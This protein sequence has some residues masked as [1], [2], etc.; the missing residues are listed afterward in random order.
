MAAAGGEGP[1]TPGRVAVLGGSG[2]VGTALLRVLCDRDAHVVSVDLRPAAVEDVES[3]LADIR[4]D[5]WE[6][7]LAGCELL[8]NLVGT[9]D[10][11]RSMELPFDD[12]ECNCT[13]ALAALRAAR[14]AGIRDVCYASTRQV[15]GR[16]RTLPVDED[17]PLVPLDV[18][19]VHRRAAEE[20]HRV[21]ARSHD[22][23]YSIVRLTNVYGP[24]LVRGES[25]MFLARWL[26]QAARGEPFDVWGGDQTRDLLYADDAARALLAAATACSPDGPIFN[27][28]GGEGLR[29]ADLAAHLGRFGLPYRIIPYPGDRAPIEIGGFIA[30]DRRLRAATGWHP[31]VDLDEGLRTTLTA[32]GL[33]TAT[34]GG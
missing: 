24:D 6:D 32:Y 21:Y 19:G 9:G 25:P 13:T 4:E 28:G 34:R 2:L 23:R 8:V 30:D 22:L 15:Y 14:V 10:H 20:Y 11:L 3:V 5:G 1:S 18:N 12:L 29:L 7:C 33:A 17:H 31:E 26:S 27:C 16:I